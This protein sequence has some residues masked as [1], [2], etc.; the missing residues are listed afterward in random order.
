MIPYLKQ[1][2]NIVCFSFCFHLYGFLVQ[3]N[4]NSVQINERIEMMKSTLIINTVKL[5]VLKET[6]SPHLY[7]TEFLNKVFPQLLKEN[8]ETNLL[9]FIFHDSGTKKDPRAKTNFMNGNIKVTK[10]K[11]IS[12]YRRD[13]VTA[14]KYIAYMLQNNNNVL[15]WTEHLKNSY[16]NLNHSDIYNIAATDTY[17][18]P[19]RFKSIILT[20][21]NQYFL[22]LFTICWSI[23][24]EQIEMCNF[25]PS[26]QYL[27][28]DG[29]SLLSDDEKFFHTVLS[30]S[31]DIECIDLAYH[32][33]Y[34]WRYDRKRA[35]LLEEFFSKGG[36][37]RV[38]VNSTRAAE[39][40]GKHTRNTNRTYVGFKKS[41]EAWKDLLAIHPDSMELTVSDLPLLHSY[42]NFK[43]KN[44]QNSRMM[45]IFYAYNNPVV[46][47]NHHVHLTPSSKEYAIFEQEFEYLMVTDVNK[48][49]TPTKSK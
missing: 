43:F 28:I 10:V 3:I 42:A 31:Q 19:E 7:Q 15:Q 30:N 1:N 9:H 34:K 37:L 24:G 29:L 39:K 25:K 44:R 27:N 49:Y 11:G 35:D 36:K 33:G 46:S 22:L 32:S 41:I 6:L 5:S 13:Y 12:T 48:T 18:Y 2:E 26:S 4:A 14:L 38:V 16:P 40:I 17:L 20:E 45:L 21:N 8:D 23:F 47:D